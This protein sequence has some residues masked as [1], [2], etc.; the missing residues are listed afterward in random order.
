MNWLISVFLLFVGIVNCL[1]SELRDERF[2]AANQLYNDSYYDSAFIEYEKI[3]D[4]GYFS[5]EL[6]FNAGNAAYQTKN[7]GKSILYYEKAKK[8][9]P[10]NSDV[11]HNLKLLNRLVLDK[12]PSAGKSKAYDR[13]MSVLSRS[14][15]YWSW[16]AILMGFLGFAF[17]TLYKLSTGRRNKKI[18]FFLG[19][20]S[21][22]LSV[23]SILL[24]T[25]QH[26][27]IQTKRNG[28]VIDQ[29]VTLKIAPD[30][31]SKTA[32]IL[33]EGTKFELKSQVGDWLEVIY[34]D[35]KIGW[36]L[37]SEVELI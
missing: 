11:I 28:I 14:P 35:G 19:V 31:E 36:I 16:G 8:L 32:F 37:V 10:S 25:V 24:S 22:L 7:I 29:S 4:S 33:H 23:F 21:I 18:G 30:E 20:F 15:D 1:S 2:I 3:I 26:N 17:L 9:D 6:F 13:I 12:N 27:Y 5:F 34:S